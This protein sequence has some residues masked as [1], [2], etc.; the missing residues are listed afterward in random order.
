ME[1]A[2][3][4]EL[5]AA[6]ILCNLDNIQEANK[7]TFFEELLVATSCNGPGSHVTIPFLNC[8]QR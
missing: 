3:S 2:P 5:K 1:I 4:L 7:L 6:L 8:C